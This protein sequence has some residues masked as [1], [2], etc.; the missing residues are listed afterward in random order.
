[1][2]GQLWCVS[3]GVYAHEYFHALQRS[4]HG[5]RGAN[6]PTWLQEGTA[7]W[8]AGM[9]GRVSSGEIT[10]GRDLDRYLSGEFAALRRTI[11][12]PVLSDIE[13]YGPFH[14]SGPGYQLGFLATSRLVNGSSEEAV[15]NFFR[16]LSELSWPEAFES[17]FSIAPDDFYEEFEA[18]LDEGGDAIAAPERREHGARP[19]TRGRDAARD[20]GGNPQPPCRYRRTLCRAP[21]GG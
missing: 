8:A 21:R 6:Y 9:Y 16:G 3:A 14:A 20:A 1:M 5:S 15:V 2:F 12:R 11:H 13:S 10:D 18:Y 17:A 19:G 7:N 4:L